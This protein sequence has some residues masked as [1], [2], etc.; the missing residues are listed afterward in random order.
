MYDVDR[1]INYLQYISHEW[2]SPEAINRDLL[3]QNPS[4]SSS[5][6]SNSR[7][8]GSVA[9][10][11]SSQLKTSSSPSSSSLATAHIYAPHSNLYS[12]NNTA[13]HGESNQQHHHEPVGTIIAHGTIT[14]HHQAQHRH[15][16]PR[17][18]HKTVDEELVTSDFG[19]SVAPMALAL[20]SGGSSSSSIPRKSIDKAKLLT[21]SH[22]AKTTTVDHSNNHHQSDELHI[23]ASQLNLAHSLP[24]MLDA[25]M[26]NTMFLIENFREDIDILIGELIS[27]FH[28]LHR[29]SYSSSDHLSSFSC[30]FVVTVV[31][32]VVVIVVTVKTITESE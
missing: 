1:E 15:Q 9:S 10:P 12:L 13:Q 30:V 8:P 29:V 6:S 14:S 27:L 31:V 22:R 2:L 26:Q 18:H 32:V 20:V 25:K 4:S 21:N 11:Q 24:Q 19:K 28:S 5:T 7:S 16:H 17:E 3:N 23:E